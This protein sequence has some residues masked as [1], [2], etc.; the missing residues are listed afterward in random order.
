M[1]WGLLVLL[2]LSV[3]GCEVQRELRGSVQPSK[4]GKTYLSIDDDNG[5]HCGPLLVDGKRWSF[6]IGEAAEIAPG[7]HTISCGSSLEISIQKGTVFRMN[8]WGP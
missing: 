1:R 5:G 8:Y 2:L 4:D 3:I 6:P 7:D